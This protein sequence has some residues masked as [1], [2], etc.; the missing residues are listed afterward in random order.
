M[1]RTALFPLLSLVAAASAIAA[2]PPPHFAHPELIR[3]DGQC[4]TI[5]GRDTFLFS[6]A[7]HYFRCPKAEWRARFR[8]IKD[9]GFNAVE[10]YVAWN[11]SERTRPSGTDDDSHIN[12]KDLDEWLSMAENG[13]G[14]YTVVRPGPYICAEWATGGYPNWLVTFRPAQ[15]KRRYWFRSDDPRFVK[16]SRHWYRAVAKVVAKHQIT[17][18]PAGAHGVILWQVENEYDYSAQPDEAKRNY[19]RELIKATEADGIDVPIFTCWTRPVRFPQGDPIL[20]QAFDNPNAYPRWN[21]E[22]VGRDLDDQHSAQPWAPKMITEFQGGWFGQVG[23]LAAEEQ[24][25]I[26]ADQT[27]AMTLYAI[28][29]GITGLNYYM[30]FGGTNFGDWAGESITTCYDYFAPIRE[31]GG[32]GPKYR[33]VQAIGRMLQKYGPDLCR[34]VEVPTLQGG[35]GGI[36]SGPQTSERKGTSGAHYVFVWNPDPVPSASLDRGGLTVPPLPPHGMNVYRYARDPGHGEWLIHPEPARPE[37]LPAPIR[38]R[39]AEAATAEPAGWLPAPSTATN[40]VLGVWDS[41]FLF[42]RA[43]NTSAKAGLLW[44]RPSGG[45]LRTD[46]KRPAA[47]AQGGRAYP[48]PAGS[49]QRFV[50]L[51]PGWPNGGAG[52]EET[53]GVRNALLLDQVPEGRAIDDWK[54]RML[55][56]D[57]RWSDFVGVGVDTS[58]WVQGAPGSLWPPNTTSVLRT[59]I[60][61]PSAP[62]PKTVWRTGGVDDEGWFYVN[63]HRV[64]ELNEWGVPAVFPVAQYLHAGHNELA[65]AIHNIGGSGGLTGPNALEMPIPAGRPFGWSWT[66]K[67]RVGAYMSYA[68]DRTR[69]LA[70]N[71]HPRLGGA[72]PAL[73]ALQVRSR[74]RFDRPK[75]ARAWE[76]LI[77]S[78]GDGFLTLNGHPLGRY[79]ESGP[80]RG[81][82]LPPSMLREHNVVELAILPGRLGDRITAAELR[83]LPMSE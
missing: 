77:E 82:Y 39:M 13:F 37:T 62:N 53:R 4:F 66:D 7:F 80:Q 41:R 54:G 61:L 69:K 6:G 40:D 11:W 9:A 71:E 73:S 65:I 34:S 14:L 2:P 22:E 26:G 83:P 19:V 60:D 78:G 59:A 52:M 63:G 46:N 47:V 43:T 70:R 28:A 31:W 17:H 38:L 35:T 74:V 16:W 29:H 64:G 24:Q 3:Y 20:G 18:R 21:I 56:K 75:G 27:N 79:W 68:L 50:L 42:F 76:I 67:V 15:T 32:E 8:A 23:G 33:V 10:T 30:L 58:G 72:D 81:Y 48:S 49:T 12:L 51:N 45:S 44:V 36:G 55:T 5:N 57:E 1:P 25:G